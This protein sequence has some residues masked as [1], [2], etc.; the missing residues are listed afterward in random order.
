MKRYV[1]FL[2]LMVFLPMSYASDD[3][4]DA[5]SAT[6]VEQEVIYACVKYDKKEGS[7]KKD[8]PLRYTEPFED[9]KKNEVKV[10]WNTIGPEG[11]E[12]PA[13]A[14]GIDGAEGAPGAKGAPG[15]PG[16]DGVNGANGFS[17][18]DGQDGAEGAPGAKG[19][20]GDL[21]IPGQDGA[22]G[23]DGVKG[24]PGVPGQDGVNG[25]NGFNG[26]DGQD[27]ADGIDGAPGA[28]GDK[29]DL[30]IP[31]QDGADG[32]DG[33]GFDG[34]DGSSCSVA[35]VGSSAVITCEDGTSAALASAGTVVVY[36][37]GMLGESPP[38]TYPTGAV[39]IVDALGIVLGKVIGAGNSAQILLREDPVLWGM[40][41]NHAATETIKL[42]SKDYNYLL[43]MEE[44][45]TGTP[46]V[47]FLRDSRWPVDAGVL[48]LFVKVD[49][50]ELENLLFKSR[51]MN[52][53]IRFDQ[54][55]EVGECENG[56]FVHEAYLATEY[57]PAPEIRNAV[58]P[59]LLHQLP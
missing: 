55:N 11:P 12:G 17:G 30:G 29:G 35:Q 40:L 59:Y 26:L 9:C 25:A 31:G 16:Q 53:G 23:I 58:Y 47:S 32:I 38:L 52:A 20:K 13:G 7:L 48:G 49:G 56:Q 2:A 22:N 34:L 19:D 41:H 18:L 54:F 57:I 51:I 39:I 36:P 45:C 43:F 21:G 50:A 46:F 33:V 44:G 37:E 24:A 4:D 42:T 28:K 6:L 15:V 1:N 14:D 27:G 5:S 3:D 10:S 8:S